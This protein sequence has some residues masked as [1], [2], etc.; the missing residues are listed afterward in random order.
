MRPG[1]PPPHVGGDR[2][3]CLQT[4]GEPPPPTLDAHPGHEP[5][6]VGRAS[7][8]AVTHHFPDR[9]A[10]TLAPPRL[11]EKAERWGQKNE[12]S[13]L[14]PFFCLRSRFMESRL[15]L[16][17]MPCAHEPSSEVLLMF[18]ELRRRFMGSLLDSRF[19]HRGHELGRDALPRV[20]ADRQ[21]SPTKFMERTGGQPEFLPCGIR[22]RTDCQQ[23]M[24]GSM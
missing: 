11:M 19:A 10:R 1:F 18:N 23:R 15:L 5:Q 3:S 17:K 7:S 13:F 21:V 6:R 12:F 4:H 9:L 16:L 22:S 24:T 14:P 2:P 20:Q 8:R